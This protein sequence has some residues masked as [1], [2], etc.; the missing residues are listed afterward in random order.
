MGLAV[1]RGRPG[2]HI[3]CSAMAEEFLGPSFEIHG[4]GL[5]LVFPT[6]RTSWRSRAAPGASSRA[7]GCT[8]GC[9]GSRGEKMSKSLGNIATLQEVLDEWG[10]R[11][12]CSSS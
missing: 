3:E 9:C 7:S 8:T 6:T 1:G 2:W 4:G 12:C 5:D 11:P 10:A